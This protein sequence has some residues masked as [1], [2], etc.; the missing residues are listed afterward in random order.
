[1]CCIEDPFFQHNSTIGFEI[2]KKPKTNKQ[3]LHSESLDNEKSA[4]NTV[5]VCVCGGVNKNDQVLSSVNTGE[6]RLELLKCSLY[7]YGG[8]EILETV[9]MLGP[10]D[11]QF[12]FERSRHIFFSWRKDIY[13]LEFFKSHEKERMRASKRGSDKQ[14]KKMIE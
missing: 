1:M 6:R 11:M 12:W 2:E 4:V 14:K 9:I 7:F 8:G 5:C 3:M 10:E 13:C